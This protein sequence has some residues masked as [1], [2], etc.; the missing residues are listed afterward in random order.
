MKRIRKKIRKICVLFLCCSLVL[1]FAGWGKKPVE[2]LNEDPPLID[3]DQAIQEAK[4]GQNGNTAPAQEEDLD[5]KN[6]EHIIMVCGKDIK[7]D[8]KTCNAPEDVRRR[9]TSA[10]K[11]EDMLI[12]VDDY[13]EAHRYKKVL[14]MLEELKKMGYQYTESMAGTE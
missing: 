5:G 10:G 9:I 14:E 2:L 13:A 6:T 4:F 12:L 1:L 3:L 8:G 7:Y 11:K